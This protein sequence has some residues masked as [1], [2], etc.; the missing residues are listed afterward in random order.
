MDIVAWCQVLPSLAY[1][2]L[3]SSLSL[4]RTSER[5]IDVQRQRTHIV[6]V[7]YAGSEL[8]KGVKSR[9]LL[10]IWEHLFMLH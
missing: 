8:G 2:T 3:N 9:H 6:T 5:D 4:L 10:H 7:D 1:I